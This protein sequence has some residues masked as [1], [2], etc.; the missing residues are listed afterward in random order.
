MALLH[1]VAQVQL[2]LAAYKIVTILLST[3]RGPSRRAISGLQIWA[4]IASHVLLHAVLEGQTAFCPGFHIDAALRTELAIVAAIEVSALLLLLLTPRAAPTGARGGK[5]ASDTQAT[6]PVAA[7]TNAA[8]SGAD[9]HAY[10]PANDAANDPPGTPA[11]ATDSRVD[12]EPTM[13]AVPVAPSSAT[14]GGAALQY[15]SV[16]TSHSVPFTAKFP[17]LHLADHPHLATPAGLAALR[18]RVERKV[19]ERASVLAGAP[20]SLRFVTLF[21]GAGCVVV[22]GRVIVDGGAFDEAD[23]KM[24]RA[25]LASELLMELMPKGARVLDGDTA[26]LQLGGSAAPA[27]LAFIAAGGRFLE[28]PPRSVPTP[29]SGVPLLSATCPL[30]ALPAGGSGHV[31]LQ[32]A[33]ALLARALGDDPELVVSWAPSGASAPYTPL[34]RV[35]VAALQAAARA[36]GNPPGLIDIDVDLGPRPSHGLFIAQLVDGD[37][38]LALHSVALLPAHAKVVVAELLRARLPADALNAVAHDLG[39]L[40]CGPCVRS[41]GDAA[42]S[43][44]VV[45]ALMAA[46][47][48]SRPALPALRALLDVLLCELDAG[49]AVLEASPSSSRSPATTAADAA[50]AADCPPYNRLPPL[51]CRAAFV[52]FAVKVAGF[53]IEGEGV[54]ALGTALVGVPYGLNILADNTRV[55]SRRPRVLRSLDVCAIGRIYRVLLYIAAAASGI[56]LIPRAPHHLKHGGDI[57]LLLAW[58]WFERPRSSALGAVFALLVE[59][60]SICLTCWHALACCGQATS[61]GQALAQVCLRMTL[62]IAVHVA[63]WWATSTPPAGTRASRATKLKVA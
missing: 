39:V 49:E 3:E 47:S 54:A 34:A 61:A 30:L 6:P 24:I 63:V 20:V 31:H 4:S 59:V 33:T 25:A 60:P 56:N 8:Q 17:S 15:T 29:P 12:T 14:P 42:V 10:A 62:L 58:S 35:G 7:P 57:A 52:I 44:R 13:A 23:A 11:A 53:L 22:H 46:E 16:L 43:R 21:V 26:A 1:H 45:L 27:E 55:F 36:R 9:A 48:A 18:E 2:I 38:L 51:W 40:L 37:A 28:A 41:T 32:F 5:A 50:A 19:S